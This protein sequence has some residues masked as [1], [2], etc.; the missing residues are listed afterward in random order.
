MVLY[1]LILETLHVSPELFLVA[2][3]SFNNASS[4]IK[5]NFKLFSFSLAKLKRIGKIGRG[6]RMFSKYF[7]IFATDF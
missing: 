2:F 6:I 5:D 4:D 3:S 1:G 7:N